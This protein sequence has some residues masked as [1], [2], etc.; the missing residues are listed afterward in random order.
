MA[1][2]FRFTVELSDAERVALR[3]LAASFLIAGPTE[4]GDLERAIEHLEEQRVEL[5]DTESAELEQCVSIR[6]GLHGLDPKLQSAMAKV[7]AAAMQ[8]LED[9]QRDKNSSP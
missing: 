5:T 1:A 2:P 7:N 3:E 9:R 6:V 8:T 4:T